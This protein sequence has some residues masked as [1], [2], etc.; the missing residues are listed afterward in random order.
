VVQVIDRAGWLHAWDWEALNIRRER[1]GAKAQARLMFWLDAV[2]IALASRHAPDLWA[3]RG[4]ITS[5][6]PAAAPAS[7]TGVEPDTAPSRPLRTAESADNSLI[8]EQNHLMKESPFQSSGSDS[9]AEAM[10]VGQKAT[11]SRAS[12]RTERAPLEN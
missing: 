9:R 1:P 8:T 2:A 6:L 11:V 10:N 7:P 12:R 3:W 5:F 4:G